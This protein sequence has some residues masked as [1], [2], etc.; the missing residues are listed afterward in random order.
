MCVAM[1]DI[2]D[3]IIQYSMIMIQY[4]TMQWYNTMTKWYYS[5]W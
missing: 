1:C 5:V 4:N 3:A 2:G